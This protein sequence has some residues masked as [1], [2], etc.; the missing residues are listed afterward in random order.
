MKNEECV[1]RSLKFRLTRRVIV[2]PMP[3]L[4]KFFDE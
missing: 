4:A 2:G 1:C 3:F